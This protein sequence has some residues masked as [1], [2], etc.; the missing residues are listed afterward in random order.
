MISERWYALCEAK[1]V[2][3]KPTALRRLGLDLVLWRGTDGQVAAAMD[4]CPH[5]G[6][7]LSTGSVCAGE[8]VCPYHGFS[9]AAGG[10]CTKIPVHPNQPIPN[11]MRLRTLPVAQAHGLI[12]LWYGAAV[13]DPATIP[14]FDEMD[15]RSRTA[16]SSSLEY[17]VHYSRIIE[18]NF[19]VYH[20]PFVHRS[21][22]P[23]MGEEVVDLMVEAQD[24]AINTRGFL[25]NKRGRRTAFAVNF[26]PPNLQLL[27]LSSLFFGVIISTPIDDARTWV[28]S[29]Y[30]QTVLRW[31]IVGR[32]LSA[33]VLWFEWS[34]VQ[35]RQDIPILRE[36][37][38]RQ[39]QPGGNVW[40]GAD[41]G[42]ARY[43]QWR[44]RQ[45]REHADAAAAVLQ[46]DR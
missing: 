42:A 30:D 33:L 18:S 20:F 29:R 23:G 46:A 3:N 4:R 35:S 2:S 6:A 10:R 16:Y 15:D 36:L 1:S 45:L 17:P 21:I 32:W 34:V 39:A 25:Q 5:K 40:V 31:P 38:P 7:R 44:A 22:D 8:L 43:V 19:D 37:E 24:G 41:R 26:L 12:W 9:F 14:W 11:A 28:W 27:R 13:A